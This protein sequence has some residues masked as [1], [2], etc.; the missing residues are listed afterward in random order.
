[1]KLSEVKS[2]LEFMTEIKFELP[3]GSFVPSHFHVTEIGEVNKKFIDCGGTIRNEKCIS[4]QLWN[5]DDVD[6]RLSTRKLLSIINLSESKLI[7]ED[8]NVEVE[9]QLDTISRFDLNF[10]GHHFLLTEKYTDCLAP[11]KCGIPV[12][13]QRISMA[14][15]GK[16]NT[17][18]KPG[19]GCC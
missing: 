16:V 4:F 14:E 2:A 3:D 17:S 7:L 13:K 15:L 8:L 11:D 6:H 1:M 5:A 18:C 9:F 12:E 10:N 19:S